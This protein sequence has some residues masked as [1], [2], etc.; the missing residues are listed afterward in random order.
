MKQLVAEPWSAVRHSRQS[1]TDV[2]C[3]V[4]VLAAVASVA[5]VVAW[6][7]WVLLS[8]ALGR[9]G[10]ILALAALPIGA[11]ALAQWTGRSVASSLI[12][13]GFWAVVSLIGG[14]FGIA[15][16]TLLAGG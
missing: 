2:L 10:A 9:N 14:M 3:L 11:S 4:A 16:W 6:L 15:A 5:A 8:G 7:L 13:V 1:L 12:L